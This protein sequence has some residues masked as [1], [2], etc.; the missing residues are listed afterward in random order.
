MKILEN[1]D[2]M[3]R[4]YENHNNA[5]KDEYKCD[6]DKFSEWLYSEGHENL[7]SD[8][9]YVEIPGTKTKTGNAV[10]LDW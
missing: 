7:E 5:V 9:C 10:I 4:L 8:E 6:F 3:A 2:E 1:K